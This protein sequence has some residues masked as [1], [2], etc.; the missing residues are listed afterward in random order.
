[1]NHFAGDLG[2]PSESDFLRLGISRKRSHRRVD[3]SFPS[4]L[5]E[6]NTQSERSQSKSGG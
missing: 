3:Q 5:R 6:Q 1:L 2:I 4:G